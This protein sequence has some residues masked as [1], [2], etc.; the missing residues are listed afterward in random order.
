MS[1]KITLIICAA[2]AMLMTGCTESNIVSGKQPAVP[3]YETRD[4]IVLDWTE[5]GEELDA[6]FVES[7]DYPVAVDESCINYQVMPDSKSMDLTLMVKP[8]T[9]PEEAVEFANQVVRY[10]NDQAAT[11]DFSYA[12]STED[13]YGGFF[14]ENSLHLIVMPDGTQTE[15]QYWLIDMEIPAGSNAEIVPLEGAVVMETEA[16]QEESEETQGDG[17]EETEAE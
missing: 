13:S 7:G 11:Q 4:D 9:T 1:K 6:E 3:V 10:V 8:G 16:S 14:E 5:I 12:V 15:Q 17:E 2:A